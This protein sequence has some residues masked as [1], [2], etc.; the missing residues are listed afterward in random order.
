MVVDVV[1]V[2]RVP[3]GY[4]LGPFLIVAVGAVVEKQCGW[5]PYGVG[6]MAPE[7]VV[8]GLVDLD[9]TIGTVAGVMVDIVAIVVVLDIVAVAA[10]AGAAVVVDIVV[11]AVEKQ[12]G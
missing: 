3:Q 10:L 9:G 6:T 7:I 4:G 2:D 11:V 5:D 12:Y 1:A 8:V